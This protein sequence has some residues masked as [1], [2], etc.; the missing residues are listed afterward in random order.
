VAFYLLLLKPAPWLGAIAIAVLAA[1]TFAP[2]HF[3]HPIRV[4]RWRVVNLAA[5]VL[6]AALAVLALA[7]NLDPPSWVA[8][9]L[10]AIAV[11]FVIVGLLRQRS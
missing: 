7:Q 5:L 10:A 4:P 1:A 8:A 2:I 6:W 11:Y 9:A 3:V